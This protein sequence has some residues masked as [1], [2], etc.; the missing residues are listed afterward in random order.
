MSVDWYFPNFKFMLIIGRICREGQMR[1]PKAYVIV[2]PQFKGDKT[3]LEIKQSR[4]EDEDFMAGKLKQSQLSSTFSKIE[5]LKL[6]DAEYEAML[7]REREEKMERI[8]A[9][10]KARMAGGRSAKADTDRSLGNNESN[11]LIL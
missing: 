7:K 5:R 10:V 8:I 4:R 1:I 9:D 2:D 6:P 3:A 11:P